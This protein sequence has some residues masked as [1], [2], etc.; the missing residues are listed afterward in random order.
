MA[1][2]RTA[3]EEAAEGA[4]AVPLVL[5]TLLHFACHPTCAGM[6]CAQSADYCGEARR[7]VQRHCGGA[8]AL[9]LQGCCGNFPGVHL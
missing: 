2:F 8:P 1:V 7:R 5:A 9:Y 3:V 4:G 6:G